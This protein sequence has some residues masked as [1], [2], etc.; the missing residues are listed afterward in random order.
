MDTTN[1]VALVGNSKAGDF[2]LNS[3]PLA[4]EQGFRNVA[5]TWYDKTRPIREALQEAEEYEQSAK[6]LPRTPIQFSPAI[7]SNGR[8]V[9]RD[10]VTERTLEP[11]QHAIQQLSKVCGIG[12]TYPT[13]LFNAGREAD[14]E[15]L[16]R[17]FSHHVRRCSGKNRT[18]NFRVRNGQCLTGIIP[19]TSIVIDNLRYLRLLSR[20]IP[21]GRISHWRGDEDSVLGN[22]LIPDT[23]RQEAD[24]EY[25]AMLSVSNSE[26][27]E[28]RFCQRPSLFRAI[29]MNGCIWGQEKGNALTI[30]RFGRSNFSMNEFSIAIEKNLLEQIPLCIE[31]VD[32]LLATRNLSTDV[33][34]KPVIAQVAEDHRLSK[35]QASAVLTAWHVE[36][37]L[38]PDVAPTLFGLING[39]TRAA[40]QLDI[41]SWR[42]L[43]ELGGQLVA[44]T[45]DR[46]NSLVSR[47]SKMNVKQVQ[48]SFE[49][50]SPST[51]V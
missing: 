23:I 15:L 39:I 48:I 12:V 7:G 9:L 14:S 46:W 47:A 6:T 28:H 32:R 26:V 24:S 35:T 10:E 2:V 18:F 49:K 4:K 27:L 51:A 45:S 20:L 37:G 13:S 31:H 1:N 36:A 40:Q 25:G 34:M 21:D 29:C 38:T 8:F 41:G 5:K 19:E 50:W 3:Q 42:Q 16:G 11:T 44:F 33:S 17:V 22:I 43:D 30:A